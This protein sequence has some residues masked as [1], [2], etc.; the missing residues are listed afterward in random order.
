MNDD[1][2]VIPVNGQQRLEAAPGDQFQPSTLSAT[3]N[4]GE[5]HRLHQPR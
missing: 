2:L 1:R 3:S 4:F 5:L